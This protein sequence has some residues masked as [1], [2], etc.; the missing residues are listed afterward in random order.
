MKSTLDTRHSTL[1]LSTETRTLNPIAPDA[2]PRH[3]TKHAIQSLLKIL[4]GAGMIV[5]LFRRQDIRWSDLGATV[6]HLSA[7]PLW[8]AITLLL[9]LLCLLCGAGRWW[10]ALRGLNVQ[11]PPIR[12]AALFMVGH[13]FN[14]FLPGS[15]GGDVARAFYVA[16]E[17]HG[18][19]TH[20][21]MSIVVER[22]AGIAVLLMLTLAG[23][24]ASAEY[25]RLPLVLALTGLLATAFL[26][27]WI[28]L[29]DLPRLAHWPLIQR[30][31]RHPRV[32]PFVHKLYAALRLCH[33]QPRLIL[34]LLGWSLLQHVCAIA[35]WL[36]LAWG[37]GFHLR[38]APFL[39]LV[40]AV[41]TA[42]MI[43][44]TPGGLGVRESASVTLLPAA[45]MAPHEAML[46]SLA[47]FAASLIWSAAGGLVFVLLREHRKPHMDA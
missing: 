1:W 31:V 27:V 26:I 30:F 14:G 36:T 8:L 28:G 44:I 39:L 24:L 10:M 3:A 17:T 12:A 16:R 20:A 11:L 15:T 45:G 41:L 9:V 43:P 23:L 32:S 13:F 19:R 40:P 22:L 33:A 21:V 25:Y 46:L 38:A 2:P 47:S 42:Q 7:H 4:I 18:Q 34:Q 5:L 6:T 35:S 37:L 29:P